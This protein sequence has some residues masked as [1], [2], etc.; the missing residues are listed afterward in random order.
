MGEALTKNHMAML[1]PHFHK[2]K[3]F[4]LL[5]HSFIRWS[6][7]PHKKHILPNFSYLEKIF[8]A[9]FSPTLNIRPI[10]K[11]FV[12]SMRTKKWKETLILF[13]S[14]LS[15]HINFS[16]T[17]PS[18]SAIA[19]ILYPRG[20]SKVWTQNIVWVRVTSLGFSS[21]PI[22]FKTISFMSKPHEPPSIIWS[23]PISSMDLKVK[24]F[25][26]YPLI[27]TSL[28]TFHTWAIIVMKALL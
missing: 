11:D 15:Y 13:S 4:S 12:I 3:S 24:R 21:F 14:L 10:F 22:S 9:S 16:N 6:R 23:L 17:P 7:H 25:F 1:Q 5:S 8:V 20:R 18:L 19:F 28:C 27:S 2:K 26:P